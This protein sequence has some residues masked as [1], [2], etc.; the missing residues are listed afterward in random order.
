MPGIAGH[1]AFVSAKSAAVNDGK[2]IGLQNLG[3]VAG[4]PQLPVE[5]PRLGNAE[6]IKYKQKLNT[7]AAIGP[8][9]AL[10]IV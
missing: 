6:I 8:C 2:R 1:G 9:L 5:H 3:G 7:V 4:L 10:I